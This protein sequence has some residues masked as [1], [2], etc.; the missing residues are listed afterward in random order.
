MHPIHLAPAVDEGLL[1]GGVGD[2]R[3]G[4]VR[5]LFRQEQSQRPPP[6]PQVDDL[7]WTTGSTGRSPTTKQNE[8]QNRPRKGMSRSGMNR[9]EKARN[10]KDKT[11]HENM[12]KQANNQAMR[13]TNQPIKHYTTK[14]LGCS[15]F[16]K[17]CW[18]G[19]HIEKYYKT[20]E[21][22]NPRPTQPNPRKKKIRV[23]VALVASGP[24]FPNANNFSWVGIDFI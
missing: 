21:L 8:K 23:K 9:N 2:G 18:V 19:E 16:T 13:P 14:R 1:R 3:D 6:A 7:R 17:L 24:L 15:R 20:D 10:D 11:R 12:Q 4:R 22:F 5:E